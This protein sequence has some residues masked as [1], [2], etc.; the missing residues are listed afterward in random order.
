VQLLVLFS[1]IISVGRRR[2]SP[3]QRVSA[4]NPGLLVHPRMQIAK[5]YRHKISSGEL[6]DGDK[7]PSMSQLRERHNVSTITRPQRS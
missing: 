1:S 2:G 5:E 3:Q 7:L 6:H 4:R